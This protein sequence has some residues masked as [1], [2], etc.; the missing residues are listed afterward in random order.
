M[1]KYQTKILRGGVIIV[2]VA[3]AIVLS[4]PGRALASPFF[5]L[6]TKSDWEDALNANRVRPVTNYYDA[7]GAHYGTIG[8]SFIQVTPELMALTAAQSGEPTDGLMMTWGDSQ[9]DLP[10]VASWE[11]VYDVDPDLTGTTIKLAVKPPAGIWSVSLTINDTWGGWISWDWNV[12][13]APPPFIPGVLAAG[14]STSITIDPNISGPQAGSTSYAISGSGFDPTTVTT[15]QADEFA[16]GAAGWSVFPAV[17]VVGGT[18][19]WNYWSA[20][21]V[22]PEPT[23]ISMLMV[24][25]LVL[26]RKKRR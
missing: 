1:K 13:G 24:G 10:Q 7:L 6:E 23:T 20:I 17:P 5:S 18:Q 3:V 25:V 16:A 4:V 15:I 11:Y 14:V 19:P 12:M 22:I 2:A 21:A 8:D 9:N 26:F